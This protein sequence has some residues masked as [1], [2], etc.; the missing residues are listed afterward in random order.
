MSTQYLQKNIFGAVVRVIGLILL[1]LVSLDLFFS[2]VNEMRQVGVGHY[3]LNDALVVLLLSIPSRMVQMFPMSALIGTLMGLGVLASNSELIAM[4]AAGV[5]IWQIV[6]MVLKLGMLLA[7][8]IFL[9]GEF[10][11]PIFERL[12][13]NHKAF[14]LSGGQALKTEQGVWMRDG[15][16]FIHIHNM[17]ISGRL[18]EIVRYRFDD[19]L[20]LQETSFAKAAEYRDKQWMMQDVQTT[21]FHQHFVETRSAPIEVWKSD[22]NPEVL[23]V[24]GVKYLDQLSLRGLWHTIQFRRANDLEVGLYQLALWDKLL[25]PLGI[26]VM[27]FLGIPF[28]LGPLRQASTGLRLIAGILLGFSFHTL[29]ASLGPFLVLYS[30][31]AWCG[32]FFPIVLFLTFGAWLLRRVH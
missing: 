30:W 10:I 16:D 23:R 17:N 15:N 1:L 32:A 2:L 29:S 4:R 13:Q 21:I 25:R 14:A 22:I 12:A 3:S 26:L 27:M 24:S 5:S 18:E 7:I 20:R 8:L 28:I 6:R 9:L 19:A 31:P 11:A